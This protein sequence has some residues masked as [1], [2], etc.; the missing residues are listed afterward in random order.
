[1]AYQSITKKTCLLLLWLL[2]YW[3][4]LVILIASISSITIHIRVLSSDAPT[5]SFG[6]VS[7]SDTMSDTNTSLTHVEAV[8]PN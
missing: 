5:R 7:V 1:M 8:S 3:L 4:L 2:W 6:R